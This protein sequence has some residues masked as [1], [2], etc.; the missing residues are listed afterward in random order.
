MDL[1][2][3]FPTGCKGGVGG[4]LDPFVVKD[5]ENGPFFVP[6]PYDND[7]DD[8]DDND[9]DDDGDDDDTSGRA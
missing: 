7:G 9:G 6:F 2:F 1:K 4:C 5:Y 3:H 8:D